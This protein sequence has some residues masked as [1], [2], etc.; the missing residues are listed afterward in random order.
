MIKSLLSNKLSE[1]RVQCNVCQRKCIIKDGEK[2]YCKTRENIKGELY[3]LI[4]GKVASFSVN[5]IEKKPIY[6]FYPGS[7]WLSLGSLGCNF[8][9]PG[10]QN[11]EIAH[12]IRGEMKMRDTQYI[13][14]EGSI[15]MA[16]RY[17]CIGIS[18]TFNEPTIWLEY[19]LD[20]A[21]IAKKNNLY[22]N[23]V[24]NG[25]ITEEALDTIGPYLD[26][27][28]VDIKG[29]SQKTYKKIAN[30]Q[31][32]RGILKVVKRARMK[33]KMHIEIVTNVIPGYNDNQLEI[34]ELAKWIRDELGKE[35]PW[36]ITR[37]YPCL[38]LSY[39]KPTPISQ[40]E[41]FREIGLE[42]GLLY[43]YLG[44]VSHHPGENTYC[45]NCKR[46]LIKRS[47]FE[48]KEINI[49]DGKCPFC[50]QTIYGSF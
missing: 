2:G 30:I 42:S 45:S 28:R 23:Y 34:K 24:T 22:T 6:H 33:W 20:S 48:I 4:Y 32:F 25:Y 44:N 35:T 14:P 38:D 19:T 17:H 8:F 12:I 21:K 40:M 43:V 39:L 26:I 27:F 7:Q 13:S 31:D 1:N 49:A 15:N 36:H 50:E 18:W 46:M 3:S 16:K 41:S 11:W 37:F 9:C 29:F 10:C 47:I 5:P